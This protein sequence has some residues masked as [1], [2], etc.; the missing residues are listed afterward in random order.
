MIAGIGFVNYY[1]NRIVFKTPSFYN[2]RIFLLID[3]AVLFYTQS[4]CFSLAQRK[5]TTENIGFK[6]MRE[7]LRSVKPNPQFKCGK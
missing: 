6:K 5:A 7:N 4:L 1:A 3:P 2:C